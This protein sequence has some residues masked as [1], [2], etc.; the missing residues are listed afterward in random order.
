MR[1]TFI[2]KRT[3]MGILLILIIIALIIGGLLFWYTHRPLPPAITDQSL[4]EGISY[5]RIIRTEPLHQIIHI[6]KIDLRA[7]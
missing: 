5:S 7:D 1:L 3:L 2:L 4:F 6:A